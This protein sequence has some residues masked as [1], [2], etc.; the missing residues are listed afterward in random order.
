MS[1]S[2]NDVIVWVYGIALI[3]ANAAKMHDVCREIS[4]DWEPR[5]AAIFTFENAILICTRINI[6]SINRMDCE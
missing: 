1:P 2:V 6:L 5:E 4:I 3:Y